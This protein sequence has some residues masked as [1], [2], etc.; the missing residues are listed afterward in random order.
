M[1]VPALSDALLLIILGVYL[2]QGFELLLWPVHSQFTTLTLLKTGFDET[3]KDVF[4]A[5]TGSESVGLLLSLLGTLI[6]VGT[7]LLPAVI[8]VRPAVY[9][10]MMPILGAQHNGV[11]LAAALCMAGGTLCTLLGVAALRNQG[12][13]G[14]A[15]ESTLITSGIFGLCRNPISLGLLGIVVGFF[16]ALPSWG[17]L[18]GTGI[19]GLN[20]HCRIKLEER[21]LERRFGRAYREYNH[22]VGRYFPKIL[23]HV[24]CAE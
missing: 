22:R 4:P 15:G 13:R 21:A 23:P 7:F 12:L 14:H 11:I 2:V 10:S 5:L 18:C 8:M 19:Y 17:A 16:L 9:L 20:T 1:N 6:S 3:A 24:E